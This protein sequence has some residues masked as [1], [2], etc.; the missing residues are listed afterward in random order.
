MK[1]VTAEQMRRIDAVTI[2]ERGIPG[3]VLMDRAGKAAARE[4]LEC[5]E[6]DAVAIVTGKGNNAGDGFVAARE[7]ARHGVHTTLY[8]LRP[9]ED[10]TGAAR[11]AYDK[12][13][14]DLERILTPS[15]AILREQLIH[16]DVA[17]DAILGTGVRGPVTGDYAEAIEA[18][19]A[20]RMN[21]VA[22]DIP[23][24]VPGESGQP[25][26]VHICALATVTMGLPKVTMMSGPGVAATGRVIIA[27]L[28]FP[29]DL[30][31]DPG[32]QTNLL[33]LA[34]ARALLPARPP[35]GH[36]GAFGR[37]MILGGSQ[38][39]S[40][41]AI[42]ASRSASRSGAGLVYACCPGGLGPVIEGALL[43]EIKIPLAGDSVHFT[44]ADAVRVVDE[45]EPMQAVAIGP[46]LG[47]NPETRQFL[48]EIIRTV[49]APL[50]IDADG[51]NLMAG[52]TGVL[53]ERPGPT[54]LTPH[55]AEA[56]RLLGCATGDI[57]SARLDA[58]KDFASAHNAVVALKGAQTVVTSPEGQ[59]FINP[60]GNSG[61][62][63]GGS[64]DVLTGLI[65]GIL[66]QGA[67]PLEAACLGV[68]A[69]GM[70]ADIA[71]E[72]QSV[73]SILPSDVIGNLGKAYRRLEGRS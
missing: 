38:G 27:D 7:L 40:G 72:T 1:I 15:A 70:A 47:R 60:T 36:K 39:L 12:V 44:A 23:S 69:H 3:E 30:L 45:A 71:A 34:D 25:V 68:F 31:E 19:N 50:V 53:S 65:A 57:Q 52:E 55:P 61:L 5:F 26:G 56:A 43:E 73:R 48:M 6:P 49:R 28:G 66:A 33:D 2:S 35:D 58:F 4:I 18:I 10:L 37:V 32:I 24:G 11:V 14:E 54:V 42:L 46:G 67:P 17:I 62:A 22:M 13:P 8:M 41:A 63:K 20:C 16:Y 59:C 64:G 9:P 21:V 29:R 51:L